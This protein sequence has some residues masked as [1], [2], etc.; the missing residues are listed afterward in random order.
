MFKV[1]K[2]KKKDFLEMKKNLSEIKGYV[3]AI[4]DE[5]KLENVLVNDKR[6]TIESKFDEI[7]TAFIHEK[8]EVI[9][10]LELN[11]NNFE[12]KEIA[13]QKFIGEIEEFKHTIEELDNF[14]T[15]HNDDGITNKES[16]SNIFNS[17]YISDLKDK[18]KTIVEY[19]N[20]LKETDDSDHDIL[21]Q[22]NLMHNDIAEFHDSIFYA[23]DTN[24]KKENLEKY[25]SDIKEKYEKIVSGYSS[26]NEENEEI[27]VKSYFDEIKD[28][29]ED[30]SAFH[31]KIFGKKD[32]IKSLD[33]ILVVHLKLVDKSSK[34]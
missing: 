34:V 18:T 19:W 28:K 25:Y 26:V 1:F 33:E 27:T 20:K 10:K 29:K 31:V 9:E 14:L 16:F 21:E 24:S 23:K 12:E 4:E 22:I 13:A 6:R 15:E 11:I 7:T 5:Y 30:L 17:E 2:D 8:N 3:Q 32:E